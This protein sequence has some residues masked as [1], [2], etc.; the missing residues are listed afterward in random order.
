MNGASILASSGTFAW[1]KATVYYDKT[2]ARGAIATSKPTRWRMDRQKEYDKVETDGPG[3][4]QANDWL[5]RSCYRK[6]G[7][8]G[9]V[10]RKE[11]G[12]IRGLG[13]L[14]SPSFI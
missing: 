10:I 6:E 3:G 8:Y 5:F 9:R 11:C 12:T 2:A 14:P 7:S 13:S 1:R 4:F